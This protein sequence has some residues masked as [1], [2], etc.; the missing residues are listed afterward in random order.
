MKLPCREGGVYVFSSDFH[1]SQEW[2]RWAPKSLKGW[3]SWERQTPAASLLQSS[4]HL[5]PF[6]SPFCLTTSVPHG[7]FPS[8]WCRGSLFDTTQLK[9]ILRFYSCCSTVLAFCSFHQIFHY[10]GYFCILY[11]MIPCIHNKSDFTRI[12]KYKLDTRCNDTTKIN[13]KPT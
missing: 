8:M 7:A 1:W 11:Y 4:S 2:S 10:I 13:L 5:N 3:K 12:S 6:D 9:P